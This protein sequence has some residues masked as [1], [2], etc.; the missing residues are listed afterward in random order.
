[1]EIVEAHL[2]S[3]HSYIRCSDLVELEL[4]D[5]QER[6]LHMEVPG[7]PINESKVDREEIKKFEFEIVE[8]LED[9]NSHPPLEEPIYSEKNF[10]KLDENSKVVPP[11][12]SLP[13]SQPTK[14]L[15]HDNG[16]MEGNFSL[17]IS[18]HYEQWLAF[19]HDSHMQQ[20]I[21][22]SQGTSNFNVWLNGGKCMILGWFI[23]TRN[24]KLIKL[25]KGS[26]TSHPGQGC[27]RHL[28]FHSIH[29]MVGP[30]SFHLS[31]SEG[32]SSSYFSNVGQEWLPLE[33][34]K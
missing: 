33:L 6:D 29:C 8:Y 13:T 7:E 3:A 24:S 1:L 25:G 34:L 16:R 15:I 10:D 14:D 11:T 23:L 12:F 2:V 5:E 21:I 17:S 9:S 19:H 4:H 28:G 20:G 26:S 32:G 18:Y 22:I 31:H 30:N 27:F